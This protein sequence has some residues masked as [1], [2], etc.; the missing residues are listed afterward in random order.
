MSR[1]S[2]YR[3]KAREYRDLATSITNTKNDVVPKM[4]TA[5]NTFNSASASALTQPSE[6][7]GELNANYITS[8]KKQINTTTQII[9]SLNT[10]I[11]MLN[12]KIDEANA[13]ARRYDRLAAEAEA[14]EAAAARAAAG[15]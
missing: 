14:A 8:A 6:Y 1:S 11:T 4:K 9:S 2:D 12:S 15:N 10:S 3:R 13:I 5:E 7:L